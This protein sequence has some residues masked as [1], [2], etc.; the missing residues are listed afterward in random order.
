MKE[1]L[2]VVADRAASL[3]G[4]NETLQKVHL[5]KMLQVYQY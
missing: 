4:H 5:Q 3:R 2:R 1:D